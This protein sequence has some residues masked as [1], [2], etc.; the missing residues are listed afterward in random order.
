MRP[1]TASSEEYRTSSPRLQAARNFSAPLVRSRSA[2]STSSSP[3]WISACSNSES[4]KRR[5]SSRSARARASASKLASSARASLNA[6]YASRTSTSATLFPANASR[7][8]SW[9][10]ASVSRC[11]SCCEV[12]STSLPTLAARSAALAR[13]PPRWM[14]PRP[15]RA[16]A[17]RT[18][19]PSSTARPSASKRS[20]TSH[21]AGSSNTASTRASSHP[22]RIISALARLPRNRPNAST[23]M[24]FP[25]PV[26]PVI[27]VKPGPRGTSTSSM[28][29]NPDTRKRFSMTIVSA[30]RPE[31]LRASCLAFSPRKFLA[32]NAEERAARP[33]NAQ[34]P[35]RLAHLDH[36]PGRHLSAPQAV[37]RQD[38]M[39]SGYVGD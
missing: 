38:G 33:E 5:R 36:V 4:W 32:Q 19:S 39:V 23:R 27:T 26:S 35:S 11:W 31:Q 8:A 30:I 9:L 37:H 17:R 18:T 10:S 34:R 12:M 29:A 2:R 21:P 16:T 20:R 22:A 7:I 14:R 3:G 6:W 24:L 1:E 25:A 13:L 28:R 15:D